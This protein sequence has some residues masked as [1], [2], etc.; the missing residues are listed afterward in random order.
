MSRTYPRMGVVEFSRQLIASK[1]LD[2]VYLALPSAME[3]EDQMARFLV[4]YWCFYS[5]GQA[6]Y[7]SEQEGGQFWKTMERAAKNVDPTP[8]GGRW[9]RAKERRHFR[10]AA[11][12][13]AVDALS[14]R[15]PDPA[16]MLRW[17]SAGPNDIKSVVARAAEH[18]LYGPWI[19]FKV[20]DMLDAVWGYEVRQD[21]MDVFMYDTPRKSILHHWREVNGFPENARPKDERLVIEKSMDWLMGELTDLTIPH[22]SGQKL[23]LFST[24]TLWCKH[25]SHLSGHYPIYND[26]VE[27]SEGLHPWLPHSRTANAFLESMPKLPD[28]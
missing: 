22:K 4:S 13:K 7:M 10:G 12:D 23:D 15:Y 25:H 17:L 19:C 9:P 5:V 11:A 26:L 18:H 28:A 1:D 24:E 16:L 2:P 20:A 8:F 21:D 27:I 14:V 3:D 6:C